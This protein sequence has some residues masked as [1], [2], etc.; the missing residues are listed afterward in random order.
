VH[1][2]AAV[3]RADEDARRAVAGDGSAG[4]QLGAQPQNG[5]ARRRK[6]FGRRPMRS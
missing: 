4:F 6:S 5:F 1:P 3:S 2:A